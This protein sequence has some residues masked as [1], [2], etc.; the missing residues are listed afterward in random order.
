MFLFRKSFLF[1]VFICFF[2][3]LN[4]FGICP[5]AF[6]ELRALGLPNRAIRALH[7]AG[8]R[9]PGIG[10]KSLKAI[11][12]ALAQKER[13]LDSSV[14]LSGIRTLGL[15]NRAN[16]ALENEGIH[17]KDELEA[18]TEGELRRIPG[19]GAKSIKEIKEALEKGGRSLA[20]DMDPSSVYAFFSVS[21]AD[22]L[23]RAGI[24]TIEILES[25]TE[26]DLMRI[27]GFGLKPYRE[28]KKVLAGEGRSL[29]S[30][31]PS[32][33]S[34]DFSTRINNILT[35]EGVHTVDK[36]VSKTAE[37]L[38]RYRGFGRK[39]LKEVETVLAVEGLSL[40][41]ASDPSN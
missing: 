41:E 39:S 4:I 2:T 34:L 19:L 7:R 8:I 22:A 18:L 21:T 20:T 33:Y 1:L 3:P 26:K 6:S 16:N 14:D 40:A 31:S 15:S 5:T 24:Y 13:G 32:I 38:M 25:K 35:F 17:T 23:Y 12:R 9:T 27:S 36:L 11:E 28:V 10:L 37:G 30:G 29:A